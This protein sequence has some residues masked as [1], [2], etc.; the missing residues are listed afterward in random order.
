MVFHMQWLPLFITL[1]LFFFYWFIIQPS[2]INMWSYICHFCSFAVLFLFLSFFLYKLVST[3]GHCFFV[4]F[5]HFT[6]LPTVLFMKLSP[7][8]L[9]PIIALQL[10]KGFGFTHMGWG[11]LSCDFQKSQTWNRYHYIIILSLAD[12]GF[13]SYDNWKYKIFPLWDAIQMSSF[14]TVFFF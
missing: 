4:F 13:V 6:M 11:L 5:F 14:P 10:K 3:D 7:L 8:L 12:M 9:S 2:K 1:S